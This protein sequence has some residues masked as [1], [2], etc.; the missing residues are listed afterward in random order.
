MKFSILI[1]FGGLLLVSGLLFPGKAS[2]ELQLMFESGAVFQQRNDVAVPGNTG[3]LLAFDSFNKGPFF[4]YRA[5]ARYN[6]GKKHNFRLLLAPLSIKVT[7]PLAQDTFY[8]D[9]TF[10]SNQDLTVDYRFNSYRLTYFYAFFGNGRSQL[11]L[12][13]SLKI[14]DAEIIFQQGLV[15]SSFD[16]LGFVP[17]LYFEYQRPLG[18]QWWVNLN[19]DGAWAPQGR[20]LDL[21]LKFRRAL[22][23][24]HSVGVGYRILE[25]G[26]DNDR[27]LTFSWFH[28]VVLDWVGTF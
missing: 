21:A 25:G 4:H 23:D 26:A 27:V 17:L 22:G 2:A 28:Y 11:N 8:V 1:L 18:S 24:T 20:A 19:M 3:D 12:G 16:N 15:T 13:V 10:S 9:K 5:E 6:W 14:R 7:G